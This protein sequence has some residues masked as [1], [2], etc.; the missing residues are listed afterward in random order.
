MLPLFIAAVFMV[1]ATSSVPGS[2]P[3]APIAIPLTE[4]RQHII[5]EWPQLRVQP[6]PNLTANERSYLAFGGVT[7]TVIVDTNGN[8]ISTQ[9]NPTVTAVPPEV[10]VQAEAEMRTIHFKPFERNGHTVTVEFLLDV[11]LLPSELKTNGHA[12]FPEVKDWNSV[13]ITLSRTACFGSCPVY[14]IEL[15]GDGT[16]L[17]NGKSNVAF[18][19]AHRGLVPAGNVVDLVKLFE[20]ADYYSLREK[21]D[22]RASDMP[23]QTISIEIDGRR[24]QVIDYCGRNMGM[25]A[26]AEQL[27]SDIDRLSGS[28]RWTQG[29]AETLAALQS[30]HWDLQSHEAANI[31]ARLADFGS[32]QAVVDL[33]HAGV[34]LHGNGSKWGGELH[35][36]CCQAVFFAAHNGDIAMLRALLDAGAASDTETLASTLVAA[37]ESGKLENLNLVLAHGASLKTDNPGG[38]TVLMGAAS[39][40]SPAMLKEVLKSNPDVNAPMPIPQQLCPDYLAH[41]YSECPKTNGRTALMEAV[42]A[43]D[44]QN[45]PAEGIDRIEVLHMLLAAGA[46]ANARDIEGKTPLMLCGEDPARAL[47]LLKAGADPDARDLQGHTAMY[48]A[49]GEVREVLL[50]N[51]A[52]TLPGEQS[53]EQ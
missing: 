2:T 40:G 39:S 14:S 29:N 35:G 5:E 31:L 13:K 15:H 32:T 28:K 21:Y 45:I 25:S 43:F 30:E 27:E 41:G 12:P 3:P 47:I 1:Q 20:K 42:A 17:Y 19:G 46:N 8:V 50:A 33:V 44:Y 24:K 9:Y 36:N 49:W 7:F 4:V 48:Y 18:I 6:G 34:P 52:H 11:A 37:A 26:A 53:N 38:R 23:T 51:G 22:C 10:V 16:V